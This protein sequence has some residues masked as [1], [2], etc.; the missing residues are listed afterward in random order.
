MFERS[1]VWKNSR[2]LNWE[3]EVIVERGRKKRIGMN[4]EVS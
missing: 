4:R 3:E 2:L 1:G